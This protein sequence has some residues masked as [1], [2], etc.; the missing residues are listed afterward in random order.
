[1]QSLLSSF[2][3]G[4]ALLAAQQPTPQPAVPP[5]N[6]VAD[7]APQ[8]KPGQ[9]VLDAPGF[10]PLAVW[11]Q[12][13]HNAARYRA[14]GVNLYV[15]LYQGPSREQLAQLEAAGMPVICAMN[16]VSADHPGTTIVGWMHGDEPDN[17]QGRRGP[18][19]DPPIPPAKV[20]ADYERLKAADPLRP[21][22]LNLGQG[23]AWDNWY[24]RGERTNKPEDY[25]E[26]CKACDIVSFDIYPVTHDHRDVRGKLEF[27][28]RGVQRL[29]AWTGE[30]KPVWACIETGHIGNPKVRPTPAQ[31]R[32]EVWMAIACGADGIIYFAHEFAP[33]FVEAAIL[34]RDDVAAA[35]TELNREVLAQ[36][37]VLRSPRVVDVVQVVADPP[38]AL[39]LRVHR[40]DG[41]LH[42]F[43]ASL[44]PRPLRVE[45]RV[46]GIEDGKAVVGGEQRPI[47][48]GRFVETYDGYQVRHHRIAP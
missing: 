48:A 28:G 21:V 1:M 30:Q 15:G 10:F 14:I 13:P 45:F 17:A 6:A 12:A 31:I 2:L 16:E 8:R 32:T 23:V 37:T 47:E 19:Y 33:K 3:V 18:G 40:H 22:L 41:A 5:D 27:V 26:Y 36:A 44:Q 11:L 25:P 43:S 35:I 9:G 38:D 20:L 29:R 42:L 24:G 4:C 7:S 34:E 46:R 39:A